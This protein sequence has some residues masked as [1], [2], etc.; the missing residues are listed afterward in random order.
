MRR[1]RIL[2]AGALV[3]VAA[4]AAI[5][6]ADATKAEPR[7]ELKV[8]PKTATVNRSTTFR[9]RV[10]TED[11]SPIAGATIR[12]A[13]R[14]AH[15]GAAGRAK[16]VATLHRARTYRPRASKDGFRSARRQVKVRAVTGPIGFDGTCAFS[17]QVTF[18]P[19][20]TN[21]PQPITQHADGPGTC[22]GTLVDRAGRSHELE[23]APSRYVATEKGDQ[24]SCGAGSDAGTGVLVFP[25]FGRLHF[26]VSENRAGGVAVLNARGARGGSA[27]VTGSISPDE[28][29]AEILS[30]CAGSGLEAVGL[31][32]N[33]STN[34]T[35]SG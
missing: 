34:G 32:A 19:P 3:A 22:T 21:S 4:G 7:L 13:K 26:D 23:D 1:T 33:L 31:D 12:F 8:K 28:D 14:T 24:V 9:F 10:T 2:A 17:G 6:P 15:T 27:T 30:K 11:G 29:Q 18:D 20:L 25:T 5:A 35:F 16:I